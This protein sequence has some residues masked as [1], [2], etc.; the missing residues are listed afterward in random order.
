[1]PKL[2]I[3]IRFIFLISIL[4]I[5]YLSLVPSFEIPV[6][7]SLSFAID[8]VVHF[9]IFLYISI[10][11]LISKFRFSKRAILICVFGFGL[12]IEIIHFYHPY[13]F[14]EIADIIAN[15]LGILLAS[16]LFKKKTI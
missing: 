13:R 3:L 1:M 16:F 15:S 14:F 8:K 2:I 12:M 10:L 9:F 11:G 4:I 6:F 5:F 7:A